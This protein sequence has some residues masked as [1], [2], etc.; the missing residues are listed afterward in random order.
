[1][2]F[3]LG[4]NSGAGGFSFTLPATTS[5]TQPSTGSGFQFNSSST[6]PGGT[7]QT[8]S[9][10]FFGSTTSI[11]APASVS[12]QSKLS[13]GVSS[14]TALTAS[15]FP[16]LGRFG[17]P[18]SVTAGQTE[19]ANASAGSGL[20]FGATGMSFGAGSQSSF[21][22]SPVPVANTSSKQGG[23]HGASTG[24]SFG[25]SMP[26]NI[27][28]ASAAAA[29]ASTAGTASFSFG[30]SAASNTDTSA[31]AGKTGPVS[32]GAQSRQ[33]GVSM[34][35][36]TTAN[37]Q[38]P[39]STETAKFGAALSSS[40]PAS[41]SFSFGATPGS[42]TAKV[43]AEN[44]SQPKALSDTKGTASKVESPSE[45][46]GKNIEEIVN[47]WNKELE[48]RSKAFSKYAAIMMEWDKRILKDRLA[49]LTL[50]QELSVVNS[51]QETLDRQLNI[52]EMHQRQVH[53]ALEGIEKEAERLYE[54]EKPFM[55]AA[56]NERDKMYDQAERLSSQMNQMGSELREAIMYVNS[57]TGTAQAGEGSPLSAIVHV[58]NNQMNALHWIDRQTN[59]L[60]QKLEQL[61]KDS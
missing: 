28:V 10:A 16:T 5:S 47:D 8:G 13:F 23:T 33:A 35:F 18:G 24:A 3:G 46:H 52:I 39:A 57:K 29:S 22:A 48:Q 59:E 44:A 25:G 14:A 15:T 6:A 61:T 50:Q 60:S 45:I 26:G 38:P 7:P 32:F 49:L 20:A 43:D 42:A 30:M 51:A 53:E 55:D 21:Q 4:G 19:A 34:S 58:L 11:A 56:A 31:S 9:G 17:L 37:T 2:S 41:G 27:Q 40:N 36:G 12:Q 54:E 1:L